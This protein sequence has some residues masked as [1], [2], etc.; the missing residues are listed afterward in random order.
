M[1]PE[2]RRDRTAE[3]NN[4]RADNARREKALGAE[5]VTLK[6]D[7]VLVMQVRALKELLVGDEPDRQLEYDIAYQHQVAAAFD[8][9]EPSVASR[10]LSIGNGHSR[11][12]R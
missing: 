7:V 4:L 1:T 3:L 12:V 9:I 6:Q 5:G 10:K 2:E 11:L 8:E